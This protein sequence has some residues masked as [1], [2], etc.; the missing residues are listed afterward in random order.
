MILIDAS[1][2]FDHTR[3][4]DPNVARLIALNP[5][6]IC[7][8]TRTE[9]LHGVRTF[10]ERMDL[11]KTLNSY[12]QVSTPESIWD[13]AGDHLALLR[14]KGLTIPIPDVILA[15]VAIHHDLEVWARDH[16]FP[17]MQKWLPALKLFQEP[18]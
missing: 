5:I 2:L 9:A 4:K 12:P 14:S 16:H 11:I 13:E 17:L 1:V 3:A 15:T 18:P 10:K 8:V 7:G 6:A